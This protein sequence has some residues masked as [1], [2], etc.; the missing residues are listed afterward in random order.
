MVIG[1]GQFLFSVQYLLV[2]F[3]IIYFLLISRHDVKAFNQYFFHEVKSYE[4][5]YLEEFVNTN[6]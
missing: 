1:E 5:N 3:D 2:K 6:N 4:F